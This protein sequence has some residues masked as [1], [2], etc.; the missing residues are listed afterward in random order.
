[1]CGDTVGYDCV[2]AAGP[3]INRLDEQMAAFDAAHP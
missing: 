2:V 1:M 3:F